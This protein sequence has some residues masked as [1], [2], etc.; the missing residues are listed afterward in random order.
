MGELCREATGEAVAALRA[1][2]VDC[3]A[4]ASARVTAATALLDRGWGRPHQRLE[5]EESEP[6]VEESPALRLV[7]PGDPAFVEPPAP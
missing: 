6:P 4:P 3:D 7:R 2:M 1:V 5:V